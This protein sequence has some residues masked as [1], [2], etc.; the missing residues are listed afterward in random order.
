MVIITYI[1]V[2]SIL[3]WKNK[4]VTFGSDRDWLEVD[5]LTTLI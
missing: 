5:W 1:G 3:C 2:F 4:I